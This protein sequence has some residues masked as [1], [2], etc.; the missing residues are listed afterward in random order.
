MDSLTR[1]A[2]D[3]GII[4]LLL[5]GVAMFRSPRTARVGNGAAAL[6]LA[7]AIALVLVRHPVG[8]ATWLVLALAVGGALGLAAA[9]RVN[10]L[11]IPAMIAFQHGA[12]GLAAVLISLAELWHGSQSGISALGQASGI[13]GLAIGAAT[14]SGSLIASGKLIGWLRPTPTLLPRHGRISQVAAAAVIGCGALAFGATGNDCLALLLV[15][16]VLSV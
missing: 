4:L 9:Y 7:A 13:L 6:A 5:A 3:A 2:T 8:A 11:Q 10:M 1:S 16:L 14:F 15:L 12:G